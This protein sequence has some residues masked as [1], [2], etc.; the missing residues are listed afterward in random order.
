MNLND[1]NTNEDICNGSDSDEYIDLSSQ[2]ESSINDIYQFAINDENLQLVHIGKFT[3]VPDI[4]IKENFGQNSN[5]SL[6]S[7]IYSF[8]EIISNSNSSELFFPLV[9]LVVKNQSNI[10]ITCVAIKLNDLLTQIDS[11]KININ[12]W[13]LY[14][15]ENKSD[16]EHIKMCLI[17]KNIN[18]SNII[19]KLI[20]YSVNN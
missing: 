1:S 15:I 12:K 14:W 13:N 18:S 2:M 10:V 19:E 11:S 8:N 3:K 16:S 6:Y 7:C 5:M 9:K 4:I 17:D 20:E